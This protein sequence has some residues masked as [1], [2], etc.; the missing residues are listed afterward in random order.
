VTEH[1]AEPQHAVDPQTLR[2]VMAA[3]PTGVTIVTA[4]HDGHLN[5]MAANSFTSV[6]LDPPIVLVCARRDARTCEAAKR[7]ERFA[8]SQ[9]RECRCELTRMIG[10]SSETLVN[11]FAAIP[12]SSPWNSD[13]TIVT[14]VG[15]ADITERS[16]IGSTSLTPHAPASGSTIA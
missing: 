15:Y 16:T 3:Y 10:G 2:A 14:P 1:A 8:A 7:P 5:G 12:R 13:V 6:S 11:E 9:V 4:S